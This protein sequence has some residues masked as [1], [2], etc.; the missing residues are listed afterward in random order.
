[1]ETPERKAVKSACNKLRYER[2]KER[3]L[4]VVKKYRD[5]NQTKIKENHR[6]YYL[7][8]KDEHYDRSKKWILENIDRHREYKAQWRKANPEKISE[9][10][11]KYNTTH[12]EIRRD[13]A[14]RRRTRKLK[15]QFEK[16]NS[17]EIYDRD[18]WICKIC[19]EPVDSE[20]K[21]PCQMSAS[22]DHIIPIVFGG[23]H[24]KDNVQLAHL[25]FNIKAGDKTRALKNDNKG[26]HGINNT[27]GEKDNG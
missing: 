13:E 17:V 16:I 24:I 7:K 11:H 3:I 20:L 1:M 26:A 23:S 19:N 9:Y 27:L 4:A 21:W 22:L 12:H 15:G 18:K 10:T 6:E 8:T 25:I 5:E 14:Q 2:D